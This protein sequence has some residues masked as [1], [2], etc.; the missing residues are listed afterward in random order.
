V[1]A[2]V[3]GVIGVV[4]S[5]GPSFDDATLAVSSRPIG[6]DAISFCLLSSVLWSGTRGVR[7]HPSCAGFRSLCRS[8]RRSRLY[9]LTR[10]R[11][12]SAMAFRPLNLQGVAGGFQ[13]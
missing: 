9:S 5:Q 3:V 2:L 1:Y 13:R 11:V 10:K 6:F 7:C 4:F 12:L 8:G